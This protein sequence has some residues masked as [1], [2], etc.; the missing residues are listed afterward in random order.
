[1]SPP[2]A[3]SVAPQALPEGAKPTAKQ[4]V[5]RRA[6]V[7]WGAGV[8]ALA[9]LIRLLF[10]QVYQPTPFGDTAAYLRLAKVVAGLS[11]R[12]YDGTR[13]PGYPAFLALVGEDPH[14]VWLGQTVLGLL[15][16]L[17][18]YWVCWRL[19]RNAPLAAGVAG[20][21]SLLPGQLFFEAALLTE[22]LTTFFVVGCLVVLLALQLSP[23]ESSAAVWAAL[24]GLSASLA[25]LTR[26]LFFVLPAILLPF[27]WFS[28][29]AGGRTRWVRSAAFSLAPILL[30]GSWL[31]FI[32]S[33]Y[34]MLS[35]T[36][37]GGYSL[38][39]HTGAFFEYL[40]DEAAPIRDT[41]L[42]YRE[43]QIAARG[44][45][46]NAIWDAIPELSRAS[47][48]GFYDLSRE[49]QR[50]SLWLIREHP[51]LYGRSVAEGWVAFW[52]A[53]IY[54]DLSAFSSVPLRTG[55]ALYASFT[56]GILI[57]FNLAFLMLCAG[58]LAIGQVRRALVRHATVSAGAAMVLGISIAQ[59][60]L[61]HGD[62]P[63]FLIPLQMV[64]VMVVVLTVEAYV[65]NRA[66][67][68]DPTHG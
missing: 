12:G 8:M 58:A 61:D 1:M 54:W 67:G 37:M 59:T 7:R 32:H 41:Y 33:K 48:L 47:G 43:A 50:L 64:V 38:V 66:A 11:L 19:S 53:P 17:G 42:R 68:R 2:A 51:E 5:W 46:T 25:G 20:M 14:R 62:N 22:T 9:G 39:Q 6:E 34:G 49:M 15:I 63:R 29:A 10:W 27:V 23:T 35:P 26:P 56:R 36:V 16:T 60:L 44:T 28:G 4:P 18:I 24:L 40:P 31:G 21:Y 52:K 3:D 55:M 45:Q 13:T 30:L 65:A 57:L